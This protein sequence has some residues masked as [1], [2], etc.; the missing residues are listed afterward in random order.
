MPYCCVCDQEVT[1]WIASPLREKRSPLMAVFDAVGSDLT[2]Y[3]CPSCGCNDR[4]RHLW[5]Y[6]RATG[7]SQQLKGSTI[8]HVAPEMRLETLLAA[9]QPAHYVRGDLHPMRPHHQALNLESLAFEDNSLD[10]VICNHVLEH[11]LDLDKVLDEIHRCLRPGG[12]LIAQTPYAP[13]LKHTLEMSR[14]PDGATAHLLYGQEDHVR[15]FGSDIEQCFHRHGLQGRLLAHETLLPDVDPIAF[16]C[17]ARE[18]FFIFWKPQE[19]AQTSAPQAAS[20]VDEVL[21]CA[22]LAP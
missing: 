7:V 19:A 21:H 16:G 5:L 18:P 20:Q 4:D 15:L 22:P 9:C 17:N 12:I 14:V 3:Q 10:L 8:L 6:L 2:H 13:L 11:V 1:H